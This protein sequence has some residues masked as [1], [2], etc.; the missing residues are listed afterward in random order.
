MMQKIKLA[1]Y[2]SF[3]IVVLGSAILYANYDSW[4]T[5]PKVREPV[6]A[7]AKDPG[8]AQ[9]KAERLTSN[10]WHCGEMNA[11][12]DYGAY[13][14]FKRF[15]SNVKLG[16]IYYEG[17]GLIGELNTEEILKT[18]DKQIAFLKRQNEIKAAGGKVVKYSD[19]ERERMATQE[20]FEDHWK[21]IC[22]P[23]NN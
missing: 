8:S 9:F 14:G 22:Q 23:P 13:V 16:K 15:I 10:G 11:K 18:L 4:I 3:G 2:F 19:S 5:L 6:R 7:I 21:E 12:N 1:V 20:V 17:S